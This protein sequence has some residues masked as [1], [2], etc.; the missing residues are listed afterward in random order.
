MVGAWF[1]GNYNWQVHTIA[2]D[3]DLG[4]TPISCFSPDFS[5]KL[6]RD[7]PWVL[8]NSKVP[9]PAVWKVLSSFL[10]F[11]MPLWVF[12]KLNLWDEQIFYNGVLIYS[13]CRNTA[14]S[15]ACSCGLEIK[16]FLVK[17]KHKHTGDLEKSFNT[18]QVIKTLWTMHWPSRSTGKS[19]TN[20]LNIVLK[21]GFKANQ[22][23]QWIRYSSSLI[24][25]FKLKSNQILL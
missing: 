10:F 19:N 8:F 20:L 6:D 23:Y 24:F 17:T 25:T 13:T 4:S 11:F 2:T 14:V 7:G 16:L 15:G 22:R 5:Q 1:C 21:M 18:S 3:G 9:S 12:R